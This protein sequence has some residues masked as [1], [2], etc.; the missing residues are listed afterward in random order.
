M[1][2]GQEGLVE[3]WDGAGSVR[4]RA[5]QAGLVETCEGWQCGRAWSGHG[6]GRKGWL[7]HGVGAGWTGFRALGL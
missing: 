3:A 1:R 4:R 6:R 2:V 7:R 5:G